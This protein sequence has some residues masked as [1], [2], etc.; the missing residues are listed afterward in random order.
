MYLTGPNGNQVEYST[1]CDSTGA[2]D[3]VQLPS[4]GTYTVNID[5]GGATGS[6]D[7]QAYNITPISETVSIDGPAVP[8]NVTTPGQTYNLTFTG[9]AG[10]Q[11]TFAATNFP[12]FSSFEDCAPYATLYDPNGNYVDSTYLDQPDWPDGTGNLW[13]GTDVLPSDGTYTLFF[14]ASC[15]TMSIDWQIFS[16]PT[17]T[18]AINLNGGAV[19]VPSNVPAQWSQLTFAGT[20][21][22][23]VT[24][25][26]ANSTYE[27]CV[28]IEMDDPNGG[29]VGG[30]WTCD[31]SSTMRQE[32]LSTTGSYSILVEPYGAAGSVDLNLTGQ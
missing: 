28:Y 13:S 15:G 22:Q 17:L 24:L 8:L 2:L 29:Y 6:F 12:F 5:T 4:D 20:A 27:D 7:V 30:D 3:T 1:V 31:P 10:Q 26:T 21:G 11:I 23:E 32:T 18:G 16:A 25:T 14:D 9:T 19:N